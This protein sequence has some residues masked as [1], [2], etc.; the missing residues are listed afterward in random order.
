VSLVLS[1]EG[2][3]LDALPVALDAARLFVVANSW[4]AA[5]AAL[6]ASQIEPGSVSVV[7]PEWV[8]DAILQQTVHLDSMI[9]Q[10]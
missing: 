2:R 10:V 5:E 6:A 9:K 4:S 1:E 3:V 8:V 7:L